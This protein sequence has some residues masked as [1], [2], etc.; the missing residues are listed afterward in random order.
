M[1]DKW[2]LTWREK[3][4]YFR[5]GIVPPHGP[6]GVALAATL[7]ERNPDYLPEE[8][9]CAA[10]LIGT[11]RTAV[12]FLPAHQRDVIRRRFFEGEKFCDIA[13]SMHVTAAR[14]SQICGEALSSI[15]SYLA[16]LDESVA[17]PPE[18]AP[19]KRTRA[20]YL[21]ALATQSTWRSR[22]EPSRRARSAKV[23]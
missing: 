3:S 20:A 23:G 13:A 7:D 11:L 15:R 14:V 16:S 19:G 2:A 6:V 18:A 17:P 21:S 5:V 22:L 4:P 9:L 12:S 1:K 10:E 8:A